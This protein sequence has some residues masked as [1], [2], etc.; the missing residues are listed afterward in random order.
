MDKKV[1]LSVAGSGK[2]TLIVGKLDLSKRYLVLTYTNA[3][4]D[5]LCKKTRERFDGV[6]PSNV[7]IFK[8]D[9]FL[10]SV[11]FK[12]MF[13][14]DYQG[15]KGL[16]FNQ[17]DVPSYLRQNNDSYWNNG[18]LIYSSRL[19]FFLLKHKDMLIKRIET[20][21][22]C[23]IIDE[24]QDIS[25]R[26]F[27]LITHFSKADVE[28][29]YVGDFY[30]HTYQ[31]SADGNY[32]NSLFDSF[33]KYV[34]EFADA[35]FVVDVDTLNKSYR[36]SKTIC[37]YV[38]NELGIH[39]QSRRTEETI[40]EEVKDKQRIIKLLKDEKIVKLHYKESY[41]YS[42]NHKNWGEVKGEDNYY[43][44]CIILN[45]TTYKM[46]VKNSL[47]ELSPST[48]AKLYVA[49]T[50]ARRNVYFINSKDIDF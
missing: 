18:S 43:D 30:Q 23:L 36:C 22:D 46:F 26:D 5:N 38:T 40:I 10:Y 16:N 8:F 20:I 7:T 15:I 39:I 50:R 48:K 47:S 9:V 19:S 24:V 31:T 44:I 45:P 41:C 6:I 25:S 2:T 13:S 29:L 11:L 21:T 27:D 1:I 14:D 4:Y 42:G 12:A 37:D 3:N 49:I 32:K 34:K 17:N 35:G 28:L 33:D